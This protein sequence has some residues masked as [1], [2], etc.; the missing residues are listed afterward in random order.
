GLVCDPVAGLVEVPCVKRTTNDCITPSV[1]KYK[2][3]YFL[4]IFHCFIFRYL[5]Q[6]FCIKIL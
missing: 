1:I 3:L 5:I 6:Y 4:P 2:C